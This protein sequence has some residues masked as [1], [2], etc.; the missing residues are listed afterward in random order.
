MKK[1][2]YHLH[3]AHLEHQED[4]RARPPSVRQEK[5]EVQP[6]IPQEHDEQCWL[7]HHEKDEVQPE[8]LQEHDEEWW[9]VHHEGGHV[10]AEQIQDGVC[11]WILHH[12]EMLLLGEIL[13]PNRDVADHRSIRAE[14]PTVAPPGGSSIAAPK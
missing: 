12:G 3:D 7:V 10:R 9:L 5:V 2:M 11:P 1:K 6:E 14:C 4:Y 13:Q 8:I